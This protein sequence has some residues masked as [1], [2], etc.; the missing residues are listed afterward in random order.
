MKTSEKSISKILAGTGVIALL[1]ISLIAGAALCVLNGFLPIGRLGLTVIVVHFVAVYGGSLVCCGI[2]KEK[3]GICAGISAAVWYVILIFISVV[4]MDSNI[5][6][7]V[8]SAA[9][10]LCG[11][12]AAILTCIVPKKKSNSR[13][14]K[15]RSR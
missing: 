9:S 6:N 2:A 11:Y 10:G 3:K 13:R 7:A 5:G 12:G 15:F 14:V 1:S 8:P 4:M